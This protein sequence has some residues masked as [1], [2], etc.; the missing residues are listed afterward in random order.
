MAGK[1]SVS[2]VVN[3][4]TL[5]SVAAL[6]WEWAIALCTEHRR[7]RTRRPGLAIARSACWRGYTSRAPGFAAIAGGVGLH[8]TRTVSRAPAG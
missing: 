8:A 3:L 4:G 1:S 7:F 5:R 2:K 6:A